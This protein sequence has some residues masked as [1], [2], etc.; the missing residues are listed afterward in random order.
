LVLSILRQKEVKPSTAWKF[1]VWAKKQMGYKH[2]GETYNVII[3]KVLDIG[4]FTSIYFLME[5]MHKDGVSLLPETCVRMAKTFGRAGMVER[6]IHS[7]KHMTRLGY[8]ATTQHLNS[9]IIELLKSEHHY[10]AYIAYREMTKVGCSPNAFTFKLLL[11]ELARV[12]KLELA[13]R[14]Y[15][16]MEGKGFEPDV[17]TASIVVGILCQSCRVDDAIVVFEKVKEGGRKPNPKVYNDLLAGLREADKVEKATEILEEVH[18]LG[19]QPED[20]R[21]RK[22]QFTSVRAVTVV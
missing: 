9:L 16:D 17:E 2:T 19:Y 4:K 21:V 8:P 5:D 10:K 18:L 7:L 13:C 12:E 20:C 14:I 6:A 1:F 22:D 11:R 3:A 15:D